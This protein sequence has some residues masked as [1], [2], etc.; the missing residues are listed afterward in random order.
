MAH[1]RRGRQGA[2]DA[3]GVAQ[4]VPAR[5]LGAARLSDRRLW[6]GVAL[7]VTTTLVGAALVASGDDTVTVWRAARD[8][9]AGS[10]VIDIEPVS[11]D[12]EVAA[13]HY[14]G[15]GDDLAG[16]LRWPVGE[17]ELLPLGAVST[18]D[19]APSREVTVAVDPLHAPA[20]VQPGDVV[21]VWT[22]PRD[23]AAA[24]GVAPV[25]PLQVLAGVTV[26]AVAADATGLGGEVGVVLDVP[27]ERVATVVGAARSGVIDLVAVPA[28]SQGVAS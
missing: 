18:A 19:H 17:G 10:P 2:G 15:P 24:E 3:G 20:G 23:R 28:A 21:D 26:A 8:L 13:G 22:T 4:A 12:R 14:A 6:L 25:E 27:V 16:V 5:R 9:A 7:L 11:V 1:G